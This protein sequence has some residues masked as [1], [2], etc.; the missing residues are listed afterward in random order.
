M[1]LIIQYQMPPQ[2]SVTKVR[3]E[4]RLLLAL[5]AYQKG[6]IQSIPQAAATYNVD[7]TTLMHRLKGRVARVDARANGH[8]LSSTKE[9]V[10]K[11]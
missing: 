4:G 10:L 9:K 8:K 3:Q 1:H 11:Q 5:Q 2:Q 7:H 6:Q